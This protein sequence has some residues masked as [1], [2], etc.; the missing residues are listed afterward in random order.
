MAQPS[1]PVAASRGGAGVDPADPGMGAL[2]AR[3][4]EGAE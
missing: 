4:A 1:A 3:G 2:D